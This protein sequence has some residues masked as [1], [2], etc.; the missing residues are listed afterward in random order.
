MATPTVAG[1]VVPALADRPIKN[2]V[3]LFD[4]DNTLTIPRRVSPTVFL[5]HKGLELTGTS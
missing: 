1:S 3:V 2:T 5:L 4:V